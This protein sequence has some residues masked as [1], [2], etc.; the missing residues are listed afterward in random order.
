[1]VKTLY[2]KE[3]LAPLLSLT[4][5]WFTGE[6]DEQPNYVDHDPI[7]PYKRGEKEAPLP[8]YFIC[9]K[10]WGPSLDQ[11]LLSY[12]HINTHS[13]CTPTYVHACQIHAYMHTCIHT[14]IHMHA[15]MHTYIHTYIRTYI[16]TYIHMYTHTHMYT[17]THLTYLPTHT[18]SLS[19][20]LT[21]SHSLSLSLT[22]R[23]QAFRRL[24]KISFSL[25]IRASRTC[26]VNKSYVLY[27]INILK[28]L[29][30]LHRLSGK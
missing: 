30:M 5:L 2:K 23:P 3:G 19:L 29:Y 4:V 27:S 25:A 6:D 13:P 8:T 21:R 16:H 17:L 22:C 11:V 10:E 28:I 20:A 7:R 1:M 12:I 26:M 18:R 15:C 24:P 9:G 14:Y